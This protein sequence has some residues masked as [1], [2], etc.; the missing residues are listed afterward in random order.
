MFQQELSKDCVCAAT[1]FIGLFQQLGSVQP[2]TEE[3]EPQKGFIQ[4]L[5]AWTSDERNVSIVK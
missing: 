5:R 1:I 3:T 2:W 4:T